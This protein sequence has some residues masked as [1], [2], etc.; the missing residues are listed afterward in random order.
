MTV[1]L[2]TFSYSFH[3]GWLFGSLE[4]Y[5]SKNDPVFE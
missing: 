3:H 2:F 1:G 5:L 4:D